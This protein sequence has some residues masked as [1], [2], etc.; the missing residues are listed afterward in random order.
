MSVLCNQASELLKCNWIRQR[1]ARC[2][3]PYRSAN[4]RSSALKLS[5][6][7]I[8]DMSFLH[9]CELLIEALETHRHLLVIEAE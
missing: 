5:Y 8:H 4:L 9:S 2:V 1:T 3:R 7:S 6:D